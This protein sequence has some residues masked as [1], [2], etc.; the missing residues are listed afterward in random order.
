MGAKKLDRSEP[1]AVC[2]VPSRALVVPWVVSSK[3]PVHNV[4]LQSRDYDYEVAQCKCGAFAWPVGFVPSGSCPTCKVTFRSTGR[5]TPMS[6]AT[7]PLCFPGGLPSANLPTFVPA[8]LE[9]PT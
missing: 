2:I 1:G 7:C 5:K 3:C 4:E 6:L 9:D 8:S